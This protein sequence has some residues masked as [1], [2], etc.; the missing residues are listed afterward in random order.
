MKELSGGWRMRVALAALLVAK[1]DLLILDEPT[2]HLDVDSVAW[3][4]QH[5]LGW[6]GGLLF[7]S[8]DRDFI[9]TVATHVLELSGGTLV[10]YVGGFAE[11]VV[12]REDRVAQ[13]EAQARSQ[14]RQIAHME[15]FVERFRYKA[16]KARQVQS[17][18]KA[19]G[20]HRAGRGGRPQGAGGP[21]RLPRAP[22][23]VPGGG[24]AVGRGGRL[25]PRPADPLG[26]RPGGGAGPQG[27]AGRP[28]RRRQDHAGPTAAGPAHP[29]RREVDPGANVDAASFAQDLTEQLDL[30]R[31]VVEEFKS[32]VGERA[33]RNLRTVLGSFGFSGE[34]GDRLVGDLSGGEK[35]RLALAEVMANPVNLLVL[36]EPTN[37]LDLPSCDV[38]EDALV[39]YPGTVVLVTHDRHLI[40]GVADAIVEVRGG[41][42]RW[43]EGVDEALLA[44]ASA[45]AALTAAG[46]SGTGAASAKAAQAT[47]ARRTA[48]PAQSRPAA[49]GQ[50]TAQRR[51]D[52]ERRQ[53]RSTATKGLRDRVVKAER[54]WERAE[55]EVVKLHAEL[56]EPSTY[57]DKAALTGLLRR[58]DD[59]KDRAAALMT[60]WEHATLAL[61]RAEADHPARSP[62]PDFVSWSSSTLLKAPRR[63]RIGAQRPVGSSCSSTTSSQWWPRRSTTVRKRRKSHVRMGA[64][65]R[66]L[67]AMT[68]RSGRSTALSGYRSASATTVASSASVGASSSMRA[69]TLDRLPAG[70]CV[71]SSGS[72]SRGRR[73]RCGARRGGPGRAR[74]RCCV[75]SRRSRRPPDH[76]GCRSR[77]PTRPRC[78]TR[79]C[80][81]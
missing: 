69:S 51:G 78:P 79:R 66:S 73:G 9:D 59:A 2:N 74:R 19:L 20:P 65:R 11:F 18:L 71:S 49:G 75:G 30:N 63:Y 35:T 16:T 37:H 58:H 33:G 4:E 21:L 24:R 28:E 60:E 48:T 76:R 72:R 47:T 15:R 43:H 57:E 26:R 17:R 12:A 32:R 64:A 38:L 13:L 53:R 42:A 41:T 56:A 52:A 29:Q 81:R 7:V 40:R 8:H 80:R 10:E 22:S 31:T 67:M 1:P 36:D 14:A 23:L 54:A 46:A 34:A 5:L 6:G 44:P 3:L 55:A 62:R 68:A 70:P 39:A 25:R 45:A 50:R 61:E 77:A 27:G